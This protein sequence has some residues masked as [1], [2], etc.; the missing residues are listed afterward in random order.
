MCLLD[1]T[2]CI[3]RT[4]PP[5]TTAVA[6]KAAHQPVFL[7]SFKLPAPKPALAAKIG[8][9][10]IEQGINHGRLVMPT[11]DNC[12][13]LETLIEAASTL[14]EIKKGVD[15]VE[16]DI[17]VLKARLIS[18]EGYVDGDADTPMEVDQDTPGEGEVVEERAH[19]VVSTR[20]GRGRKNV[21]DVS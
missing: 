16:Q 19:S 4:D 7:R 10:L 20:S 14:L 8:Q 11:K 13:Q 1:L 12:T 2:H 5:P 15:R 6:T 9:V 18:Q 17:R 3:T 21:S